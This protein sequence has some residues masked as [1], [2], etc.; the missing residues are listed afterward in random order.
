M[1]QNLLN[2]HLQKRGKNTT[3]GRG[4]DHLNPN[5]LNVIKALTYYYYP[6]KQGCDEGENWLNECIKA[7]EGMK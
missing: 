4:K 1:Q 5:R 3:V 7:T 2:M 6:L